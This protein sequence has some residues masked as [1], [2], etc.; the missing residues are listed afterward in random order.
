MAKTGAPE[1]GS[2]RR[3]RRH[4][5][6]DPPDRTPAPGTLEPTV[7][8]PDRRPKP[9][10]DPAISRRRFV[11]LGVGG[12]VVLGLGGTLAYQTSG[13]EIPDAVRARLY[14]LTPKEYIVVSAL[15][16]RILRR[17]A[18]D[19]P[20]PEEVEAAISIDLFV[21]RMDAANRRDLLRLLHALEHVLPLSAGV[22]SRFTRA[23]GEEQDRVLRTMEASSQ[24]I[25]RGAFVALKSLC[26]LAYFSHPLTW[27][28]IGYDGPLVARPAEG[29]VAAARLSRDGGA[30]GGGAP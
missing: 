5:V 6:T 26:A 19:L 9:R 27:G 21:A 1:Y 20:L 24:G 29:W 12:A 3:R 11:R 16:A 15:A 17:D 13:Y 10:P 14:A 23:S 2:G 30:G 7:R 28:A 4:A 8:L 18:D 22:F 25:L